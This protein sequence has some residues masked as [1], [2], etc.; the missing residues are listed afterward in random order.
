MFFRNV[1]MCFIHR[2]VFQAPPVSIHFVN[3]SSMNLTGHH[4]GTCL[5]SE[6]G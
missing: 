1:L 5:M 3:V 6:A 2:G 4:V